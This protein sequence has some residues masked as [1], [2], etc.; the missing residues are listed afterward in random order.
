MKRSLNIREKRL[1]LLCLVTLLIVGNALALS[2][3]LARL[4]GARDSITTLE[5]ELAE[6]RLWLGQ[7]E[8]FQKR[9]GWID[10]NMPYIPSE[11][12]GKARGELYDDLR[13]SA[14]DAGLTTEN[15]NV[16]NAAA[17]ELPNA[18]KDIYANEVSVSMRVRGDQ[19]T[20]IGWLLSLQ[21]TD[22]FVVVKAIELELDSRSK[23]KT[24]QAQCDITVA[25]W[26]NPNPP[27]GTLPDAPAPAPAA[28]VEPP[29]ATPVDVPS[30]LDPLSPVD[31][32]APVSPVGAS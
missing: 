3:F 4:K 20:L 13:F 25:R 10:K 27:P 9:Q 16:Q 12:A 14:F 5:Q 1:L 15:V 8:R 30:P 23:E 11:Q 22:R 18:N 19:T 17:L 32:L 7:Q 29:L 28:P 21:G 26:F 6:N 31:P 2:N 24:P